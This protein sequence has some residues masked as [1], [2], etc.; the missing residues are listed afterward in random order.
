MKV[1]YFSMT[2]TTK[3]EN[4]KVLKNWKFQWKISLKDSQFLSWFGLSRSFVLVCLEV[5]VVQRHEEVSWVGDNRWWDK[6][7]RTE[8]WRRLRTREKPNQWY[9]QH[10]HTTFVVSEMWVKILVQFDT[11]ENDQR[12]WRSTPESLTMKTITFS[13]TVKT[14]ET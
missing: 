2:K 6:S 7:M 8:Y 4:I 5:F 3:D 14:R 9:E 12:T 10:Q 13:I 1:K 11:S